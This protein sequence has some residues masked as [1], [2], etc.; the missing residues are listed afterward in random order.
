LKTFTPMRGS[1][2]E[3]DVLTFDKDTYSRYDGMTGY[4]FQDGAGVGRVWDVR[5]EDAIE[6]WKNL[7]EEVTQDPPKT[8]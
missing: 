4:F 8:A 5:D 3:G 6:S 7:F 1:F 2:E